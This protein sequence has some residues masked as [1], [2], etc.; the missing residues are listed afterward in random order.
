MT[1]V[2]RHVHRVALDITPHHHHVTPPNATLPDHPIIPSKIVCYNTSNP[3]P[4]APTSSPDTPHPHHVSFASGQLVAQTAAHPSAPSTVYTSHPSSSSDSSSI[5]QPLC[6]RFSNRESVARPYIRA[7]RPA[8]PAW[9][10]CCHTFLFQ[11]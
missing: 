7:A 3:S 5:R 1:F 2:Y 6:Y 10:V 11:Q 9:L 4:S 8:S